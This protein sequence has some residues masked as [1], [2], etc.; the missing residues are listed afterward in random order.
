[1]VVSFNKEMR[2]RNKN[3]II[4]TISLVLI[5][6]LLIGMGISNAMNDTVVESCKKGD[7]VFIDG[8]GFS[9]APEFQDEFIENYI[10]N[11]ING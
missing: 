7:I 6:F 4:V 8:Q 3:K 11:P 2:F 5:S 10:S 9:V 1:M